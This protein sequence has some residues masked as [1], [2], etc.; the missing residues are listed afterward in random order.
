MI[1]HE[2]AAFFRG[3]SHSETGQIFLSNHGGTEV[4]KINTA[5]ARTFSFQFHSRSC[6][7][8]TA[9]I[10]K[11]KYSALFSLIQMYSHLQNTFLVRV[12]WL[13]HSGQRKNVKKNKQVIK[14]YAGSLC[15]FLV[16]SKYPY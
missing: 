4:S 5:V 3:H 1:Y 13:S 2:W 11:T 10:Y 12:M 15:A 9:A 14:T 16:C 7:T 6:N 8:W